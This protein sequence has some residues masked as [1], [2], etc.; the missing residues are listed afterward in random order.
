MRKRHSKTT[1]TLKPVSGFTLIEL[2]IVVVILVVGA[3]LALPSFRSLLANNQTT[4]GS[5]ELLTAL[6]LA[7]TEA[8]KR[9]RPVVLCGSADGAACDADWAAG[10]MV[11]NDESAAGNSDVTEG[12]VI[13]VWPGLRADLLFDESDDDLPDFV[14]FL[15]DGRIDGL[16]LSFPLAFNLRKPNCRFG[17]ARQITVARTGRAT[18]EQ[19]SC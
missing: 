10:W 6:N 12:T 13:R 1:A 15:P 17:A 14:R 8:L 11:V 4:T 3:T 19:D 16:G 5:N 2:L 7:R 18:V 9:G